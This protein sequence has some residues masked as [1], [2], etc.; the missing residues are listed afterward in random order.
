M[1]MLRDMSVDAGLAVFEAQTEALLNRPDASTVLPSI[2]CPTCVIVGEEDAWS[3]VVQHKEIAARI[4]GAGLEVV[5]GAGHMAP[6]EA[7]TAFNRALGR[8]MG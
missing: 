5:T 7:P 4:A 8:W 1:A 2:T 6:A 3:P